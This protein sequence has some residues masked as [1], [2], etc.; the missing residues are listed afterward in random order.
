MS[1]NGILEGTTPSLRIRVPQQIPVT[2]LI[3]IELVLRHKGVKTKYGLADMTVDAE[4]NMVA[5]P[6]TERQTLDMD[7]DEPLYWQIRF[8]TASGIVGTKTARID[9]YELRS[10][11]EMA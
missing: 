7:P 10:E 9:V 8:K 5:Y 11:E 6:F 1:M 3:G 2:S 4:N